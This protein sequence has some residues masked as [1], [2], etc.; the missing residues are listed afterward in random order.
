MRGHTKVKVVAV[1]ADVQRADGN[2]GALE[3]HQAVGKPASQ[4][5]ALGHDAHHHEVAGTTVVLQDRVSDPRERAPDLVT[6]HHRRFQPAL[7]DAHANNLSN[8]AMRMYR[9]LRA[10]RKY[11]AL[12][13]ASTSGAISS[14]LGRGC[15]TIASFLMRASVEPSMR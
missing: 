13:S 4:V 7:G 10:W 15:I 8:K 5:V 2:R 3:L 11:A 14:T 1:L 6:I 12:G 9:P